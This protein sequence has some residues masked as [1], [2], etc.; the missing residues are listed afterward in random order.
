MI[1][2]IITA[3]LCAASVS[4]AAL[5]VKLSLP[6][7]PVGTVNTGSVEIALPE[8]PAVPAA[9]PETPEVSSESVEVTKPE[10]ASLETPEVL[11]R[12]VQ[13]GDHRIS[14]VQ[15]WHALLKETFR[16]QRNLKWDLTTLLDQKGAWEKWVKLYKTAKPYVIE[17]KALPKG[18][19][20]ISEVK[21]PQSAEDWD[22]LEKNLVYYQKAGYNGVLLSFT[23]SDPLPELL[24]LCDFLKCRKWKIVFAFSGAEDLAVSAFPDP[25]ELANYLAALGVRCDALLLGWRR[26]SL[27]LLTPDRQYINHLVKS[28]RSAN[29]DLPVI[30]MAYFGMT[31]ESNHKMVSSYSI[32]E[33]VSAVLMINIGYPFKDLRKVIEQRFPKIKNLPKIGQAL[34]P[35]PYYDSRF[36]IK[37]SFEEI[38][39]IKRTIEEKFLSAGC[40]GTM[41]LRGDGS[42]GIYEK[43]VNENLSQPYPGGPHE[44]K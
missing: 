12:T 26:T 2:K 16:D 43:A 30:G 1:N 37:K 22:T 33:G 19:R 35:Y 32:P 40:I 20:I 6:E 44:V 24:K 23:L 8:T 29:A 7:I 9:V 34:G 3:L 4:A 36:K 13:T 25:D 42:D 41:T 27:H 10:T 39:K 15:A 14:E 11:S 5:E 18:L 21:C 38:Q 28:A 31:S 17:Y